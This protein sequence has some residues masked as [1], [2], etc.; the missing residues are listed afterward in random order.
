MVIV[1][2]ENTIWEHGDR[3]IYDYWPTN[4]N[5]AAREEYIDQ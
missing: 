5:A 2:N 1:R 3:D 4:S